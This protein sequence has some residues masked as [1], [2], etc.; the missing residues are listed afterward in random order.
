MTY[1]AS[2]LIARSE[3][4]EPREAGRSIQDPKAGDGQGDPGRYAT[5]GLSRVEEMMQRAGR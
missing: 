2:R 5:P 1:L 3:V 4:V